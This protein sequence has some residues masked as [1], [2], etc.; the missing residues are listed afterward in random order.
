MPRPPVALTEL[1]G[2]P[3]PTR[4]YRLMEIVR[5]VLLERR[6]AARTRETYMYWIR[7]FIRHHDRRHPRDMGPAEVRAFLSHLAVERG[8]AA[9]T[10]NQALAAVCF[11]YE[12]VLGATLPR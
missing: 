8:V 7:R 2:A 4:P 6:Y 3:D 11:L 12:H 1:V 10:Q 9:A 5:R